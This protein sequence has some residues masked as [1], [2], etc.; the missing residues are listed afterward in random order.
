[1][2]HKEFIERLTKCLGI[3]LTLK[4]V[5]NSPS[6]LRAICEREQSSQFYQ[7]AL[8]KLIRSSLDVYLQTGL[9][10]LTDISRHQALQVACSISTLPNWANLGATYILPTP[11][12]AKGLNPL[13]QYLGQKSPPVPFGN[14]W[15]LEDWEMQGMFSLWDRT[16]GDNWQDQRHQASP[17][18]LETHTGL[19][20]SARRCLSSP[21]GILLQSSGFRTRLT[22]P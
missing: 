21:S 2:L 9:T 8:F 6:A 3:R 5:P 19:S 17:P 18:Y 1:M 13:L 16:H 10:N 7:K 22:T 14:H 11:A 20:F 4:C 12:F 15:N